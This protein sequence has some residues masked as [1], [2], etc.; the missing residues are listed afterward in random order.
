MTPDQIRELIR[1]LHDFM[2]WHEDAHP[3][4]LDQTIVGATMAILKEELLTLVREGA[5]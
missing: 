1:Q 2:C 4:S 5:R 3:G